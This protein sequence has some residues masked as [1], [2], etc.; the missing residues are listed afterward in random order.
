[1]IVLRLSS[2]VWKSRDRLMPSRNDV[3][4]Q[5]DQG[6]K[7]SRSEK[8]EWLVCFDQATDQPLVR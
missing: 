1:M 2:Q 4:K 3:E 5:A 8:H 7:N 6:R